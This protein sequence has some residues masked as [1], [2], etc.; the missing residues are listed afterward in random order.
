MKNLF[1]WGLLCGRTYWRLTSENGGFRLGQ[2]VNNT[3]PADG[4]RDPL[5]GPGQA[6]FAT[7]PHVAY[8]KSEGRYLLYFNGR[9]WPANDLTNCWPS[10]NKTG[11][12]IS[13]HL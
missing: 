2:L 3:P 4:R 5:S 6:S 7:N 11:D 13:F 8:V 12:Q 1:F 10:D 9:A